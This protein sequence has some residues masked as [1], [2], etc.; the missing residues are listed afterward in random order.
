MV[1]RDIGKESEVFEK[2]YYRG[3]ISYSTANTDLPNTCDTR[4]DSASYRKF[5]ESIQ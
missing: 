2:Y 5:D 4:E 3:A 1:A